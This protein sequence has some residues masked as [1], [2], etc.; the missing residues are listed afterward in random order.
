MARALHA[1]SACELPRSWIPLDLDAGN[2]LIEDAMVRF[3]DLDDSR[4]GAA[5]LAVSTFLRRASRRRAG[6][7]WPLWIEAVRRAYEKSWTPPLDL[8]TGWSDLDAASMLI[9]CHL[10]WQRLEQ[11]IERGEV[12]GARE[13]AAARTAQRLARALD[14]S[15]A[16][17]PL[18]G[19]DEST[20]RRRR[21]D[22]EVLAGPNASPRETRSRHVPRRDR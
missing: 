15:A 11:R 4:I 1:L 10:G 20:S 13:L 2:V 21:D 8:R 17:I 16:S 18:T 12:H 19:A 22:H 9:D 14:V 7:D 5:S 6:A 3:I